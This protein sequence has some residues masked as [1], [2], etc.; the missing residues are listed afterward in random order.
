MRL[1]RACVQILDADG[2]AITLAYTGSERVTLCA[3]DDAASRIEDLQ[4]VLGQGPGPDAY[5]SGEAVTG[6]LDGSDRDSPWALLDDAVRSALGFSPTLYAL[7]IKPGGGVLGVL[8]L[9]Q[10]EP[11][12]LAQEEDGAQF[13]AD[14]LGTAL[15]KDPESQA[16]MSAGPWTARA[17][18]H[19]ATGIVV[20]QLGVLPADALA[21]LR[22]HAFAHNVSMDAIAQEVLQRRL[23]FTTTD[24]DGTAK[25]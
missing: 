14:A 19:Q 18:I 13:L 17:E 1:C 12:A 7:P 15:L 16:E 20:A 4:D 3:T 2:G 11:R 24:E 23:D 22:A 8:T 25:P 10:V 21:L 6:R 5:A 9:Y